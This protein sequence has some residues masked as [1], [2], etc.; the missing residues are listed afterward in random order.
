[1]GFKKWSYYATPLKLL[2]HKPLS[3]KIT[4]AFRMCSP[5]PTLYFSNCC[6]F[7]FTSG[8]NSGSL[9]KMPSASS[10]SLD[11]WEHWS[12]KSFHS[13][14]H[15]WSSRCCWFMPVTSSSR[16]SWAVWMSCFKASWP[17]AA[18]LASVLLVLWSAAWRRFC[19]VDLV[20]INCFKFLALSWRVVLSPSKPEFW[21]RVSWD[22]ASHKLNSFRVSWHWLCSVA[23]CSLRFSWS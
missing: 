15:C 22:E 14:K 19:P 10:R 17:G 12:S 21:A 9:T 16:L 13:D 1:M 23:L 5:V 2:I 6:S 20:D 7:C 11:T 18:V 3:L 4:S 8:I